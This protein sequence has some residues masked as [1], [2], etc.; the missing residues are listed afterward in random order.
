[1]GGGAAVA[2]GPAVEA[3][4]TVGRDRVR[5][6]LW[7][8][9]MSAEDGRGQVLCVTG[10]PGIGKT[11]LVEDFLA[12]LASGGRAHG[13]ARGRCSERLAGAEAYLPVLEALD[14]LL[15][16]AGG[17]AAARAMGLLA[18]AWY[19]RVA[20]AAAGGPVAA[21]GPA[22]PPAAATQEQSKREMLAFLEELSRLRPVVLF[23]DDV[24]W[25]DAST[26]DLLA[27]LGARC[28]GLRMLVLLTYRPTELLLGPHPFVP[29]Q[30]ELQRH[31]ACR[32]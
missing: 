31:P 9:F 11:T 10:E 23:L 28:A 5:V 13:G 24:H 17:E 21:D 26:V 19:A 14:G 30:L 3:R 32:A 25:A 18:P 6:G 29:A 20:P 12:E 7:E 27:Y 4:L 1:G 15:R 16:G 8:A 22:A 2:A